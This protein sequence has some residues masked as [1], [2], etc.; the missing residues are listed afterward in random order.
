MPRPGPGLGTSQKGS[1][2]AGLVVALALAAAGIVL[3]FYLRTSGP[4]PPSGPPTPIPTAQASLLTPV[5]TPGG[6]R[7]CLIIDDGGYQR[8][9]ALQALYAIKSPITVS[10]IPD[11]E[12]SRVLAEEFPDHGVEVMCHM[13]ME[14]HEKGSVGSH[15]KAL[16]RK[17]MDLSLAR[18]DIEEALEG[19]PHCR[20]LNNHMGSVATEELSLMKAVCSVLHERG[21]YAIDSRTTA[22]SQVA[23]AAS[24]Q[25]VACASRNVFLDNQETAPAIQKQLDQAA[26]YARKHG[27]AVAIG[28]FKTLTLKV[29]GENIPRLEAQGF[30]FVHASEVVK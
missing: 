20:G 12:F 11:V 3:W 6:S 30:R 23:R 18:R 28:H 16:I 4:A 2:L 1:L 5:A 9:N 29:L 19:L 8:G 25:G 21:L 26:A 27:V 15:Y 10:I 17:G 22:K 24:E 13:P 14:G 7:I